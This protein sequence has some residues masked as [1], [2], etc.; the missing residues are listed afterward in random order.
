[1]ADEKENTRWALCVLHYFRISPVICIYKHK[2]SW[3][4]VECLFSQICTVPHTNTRLGRTKEETVLAS[5]QSNIS[6][7]LYKKLRCVGNTSGRLAGLR[8]IFD[9]DIPDISQTIYLNILGTVTFI[10]RIKNWRR[11]C[12]IGSWYTFHKGEASEKSRSNTFRE[13]ITLYARIIFKRTFRFKR[14]SRNS[15]EETGSRCLS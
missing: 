14:S 7:L 13:D 3:R 12:Q 6:R 10:T 15:T 5:L 1:M 9:P 2:V 4:E 11:E 8:G